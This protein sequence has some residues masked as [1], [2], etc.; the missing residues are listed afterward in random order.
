MN[1]KFEITGYV[2]QMYIIS[3]SSLF[4]HVVSLTNVLIHRDKKKKKNSFTTICQP[5]LQ[6]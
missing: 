1:T 3:I 6:S 4:L 2:R 5:V